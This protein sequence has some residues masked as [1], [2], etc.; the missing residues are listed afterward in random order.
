MVDA[1]CHL[2]DAEYTLD[3]TEENI[4][5]ATEAG[6][7]DIISNGAGLMSCRETIKL[8]EMHPRVWATVG[9]HPEEG[10]GL[11]LSLSLTNQLLRLAETA[12]VVAVGECGLDF[13]E[14]TSVEE[15]KWQR[16][17]FEF[18][19]KLAKMARLPIV[20]HNRA[21]GEEIMDQLKNFPFGVQLHCFVG[22]RDLLEEA[23]KRGYYISVGGIATFKSSRELRE[24]VKDIPEERLLLETDAPYL[25]PEPM[26]GTKNR[27]E[28]VRWVGK[29]VA[30]LRD[31]PEE[32]ID[33]V[34]TENARRLFKKMV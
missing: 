4:S 18:N 13:G 12:S 28:N 29:M 30:T 5:R 22:P 26:R 20:V 2:I 3:E 8:A 11:K 7:T 31:C 34:T 27:P 21:A 1:H 32:H 23:V 15:R 19:I 25:A 9:I 17:L 16:E 6:V 24:L 14:K 33:K 10:A